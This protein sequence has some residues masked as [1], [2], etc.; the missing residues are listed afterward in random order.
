MTDDV[1]QWPNWYEGNPFKAA[2]DEMMDARD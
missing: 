2:R 1:N